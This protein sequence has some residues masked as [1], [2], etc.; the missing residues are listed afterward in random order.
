VGRNRIDVDVT[1]SV[2]V[3]VVGLALVLVAKDPRLVIGS[4][5]KCVPVLKSRQVAL[6][7]AQSEAVIDV[8]KMPLLSGSGAGKLFG[9]WAT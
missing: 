3:A 6:I 5:L 7:A 8:K 4:R 1:T 2:R 9:A